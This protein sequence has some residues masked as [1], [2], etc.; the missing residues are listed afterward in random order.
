M[1][2]FDWASGFCS[3]DGSSTVTHQS[4]FAMEDDYNSL[5]MDGF[6]EDEEVVVEGGEAA[7]TAAVDSS[8]V[9]GGSVH[10][11][12]PPDEDEF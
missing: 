11:G 3:N 8:T 5:A 7:A 10:S 4:D 2:T 9:S 6:D 12:V 1:A